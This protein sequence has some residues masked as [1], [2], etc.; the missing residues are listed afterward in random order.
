[1]LSRPGLDALYQQR[2]PI[3]EDVSVITIDTDGRRPDAIAHDVLAE[4]TR[5][6]S[7]PPP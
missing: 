4:L 3:Y 6:P 2:L 5:L 1:M 7:I